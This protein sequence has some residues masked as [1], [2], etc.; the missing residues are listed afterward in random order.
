MKKRIL[1]ILIPFLL[2]SGFASN[3]LALR[4]DVALSF[5]AEH[6]AYDVVGKGET[7]LIFI[8]GWSCDGRYWQNQLSVFAKEYQVITVDLAGHGHSS[9][10]IL[11]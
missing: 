5:D 8:H 2:L 9:F 4:H 1:L 11:T 6:I 7:A 10:D 3:Q